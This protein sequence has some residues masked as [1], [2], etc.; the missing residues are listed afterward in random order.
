MHSEVKQP[1]TEDTTV[2]YNE[3]LSSG[4]LIRTGGIIFGFVAAYQNSD[5]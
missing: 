4:I 1:W 5:Q 2:E 3:A